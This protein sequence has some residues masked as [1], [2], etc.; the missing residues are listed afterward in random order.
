MLVLLLWKQF[1]DTASS[2]CQVFQARLGRPT[3]NPHWPMSKQLFSIKRYRYLHSAFS[4]IVRILSTLTTRCSRLRFLFWKRP[5]RII[6][7]DSPTRLFYVRLKLNI[8]CL[9]V[10]L[11]SQILEE[12]VRNTHASTHIQYSLEIEQ[13]FKV[14]NAPYT[15][16]GLLY[17]CVDFFLIV[18]FR[19]T[20]PQSVIVICQ[21]SRP[22][23]SNLLDLFVKS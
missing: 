1:L 15:D 22:S 20:L 8:C 19:R 12:Y 16:Y 3:K 21:P 14:H 10:C 5:A 4:V 9:Y 18:F 7:S 23:E 17:S 11:F 13:I 6:R 2:A